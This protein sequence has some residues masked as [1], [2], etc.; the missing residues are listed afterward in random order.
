V[1]ELI[2][3]VSSC[4]LD[5]PLYFVIGSACALAFIFF[6]MFGKKTGLRLDLAFWKTKASFK[7]NRRVWVLSILA[8]IASILMAAVLANP[9]MVK[10]QTVHIY[11]KPVMA[12]IDVS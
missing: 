11:G 1:E 8:A 7:K 5:S 6:P 4:K 12:V 9:Y 10:K 2:K 3:F